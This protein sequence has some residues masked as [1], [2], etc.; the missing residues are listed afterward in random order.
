LADG[1]R[2]CAETVDVWIGARRAERSAQAK[3]EEN[4]RTVAD[5]DY[6]IAELRAA[7]AS[8]ENAID[9]EHGTAHKRVVELNARAERVEAELV[10]L[11]TR[12]CEPL[13]A[14]PELGPLFRRLESKAVPST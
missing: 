1:Y 9:R 13:R 4:E 2:K 10:K 7:L 12:F 6:Q 3:L 14:R 8:H 5:L 11:A